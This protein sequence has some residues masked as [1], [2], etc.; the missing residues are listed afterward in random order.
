MDNTFHGLVLKPGHVKDQYFSRYYF[1]FTLIISH[2]LSDDLTTNAKLIANDTSLSVVHKMNTSTINL[3]N[4]LNKT[5]NWES[6][7]K[8]ILT[9]VLVN[10]IRNLY[11]QE[12]FKRQIIIQF[13]SIATPLNQ[14]LSKTSL[15]VPWY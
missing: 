14:F 6:H 13:I 7:W 1:W 4:D 5:R 12:N 10:K 11:F 9:P 8:W 3:N 15:N 2:Y